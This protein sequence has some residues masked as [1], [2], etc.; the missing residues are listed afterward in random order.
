MSSNLSVMPTTAGPAR[1]A[2]ALL[3][4]LGGRQ[5]VIRL[6]GNAVPGN[7][8]EQ[9]GLVAPLFQDVVLGP[10]VFRRVRAS[11]AEKT[12][13][14]YELLVSVNAITALMGTLGYASADVLFGQA[15]GVV[16]DQALLEIETVTSSEA[17]GQPYLY[18]L[19][20]R[21]ALQQKV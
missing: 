20:M 2:D 11:M 21:G 3:R 18:R 8:Q 6:P 13:A 9:L 1:V 7:D 17:F 16:V 19:Q 4:S 10:V 14:R 5:V 15:V 12:A